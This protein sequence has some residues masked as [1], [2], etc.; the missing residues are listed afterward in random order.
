MH[1]AA[2]RY[3]SALVVGIALV[4]SLA[5]RSELVKKKPWDVRR[6]VAVGDTAASRC[7][8]SHIGTHFPGFG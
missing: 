3:G 7:I 4:H 8:E 5:E 1:I 6:S 2:W